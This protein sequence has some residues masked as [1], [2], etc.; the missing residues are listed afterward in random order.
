[1]IICLLYLW[2]PSQPSQTTWI[3]TPMITPCTLD[4]NTYNKKTYTNYSVFA[5]MARSIIFTDS[6]GMGLRSYLDE[7]SLDN[8]GVFTYAGCKLSDIAVRS[9]KEITA[10]RPQM[11]VYM[12]GIV[13]LTKKNPVA[14]TLYVRQDNIA[15]MTEEMMQIMN[16][17]RCLLKSAFPKM[18]VIF[19][20]VCGC[21]MNM[22]MRKPG[23][24]IDQHLLDSSVLELN[25]CIRHNNMLAEVPHPYFTSKVHKWI[26]GRC[27]HRYHLLFDGLHPSDIILRQWVNI[28]AGLHEEITGSGPVSI[29]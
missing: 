5:K 29:S 1:M 12:G 19:G 28:L 24:A 7:K 16:S 27:H 22:Y 18:I 9:M 3:L 23:I 14:K 26:S 11:V 10:Y 6:R 4:L 17:I 13:D 2:K 25:R 20:G 15:K 21:D 8:I